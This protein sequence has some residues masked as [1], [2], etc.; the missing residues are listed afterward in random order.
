MKSTS[1]SLILHV[2][3]YSPFVIYF[4]GNALSVSA[5][6]AMGAFDILPQHHRFLT[7]LNKCDV[8]VRLPNGEIKKI[9]I[10]GG[11]MRVKDDQTTVFL[12]I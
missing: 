1:N 11:V 4:D 2:K 8:I 6:N 10:N 7:L 5:V 3:I 12:D 9:P